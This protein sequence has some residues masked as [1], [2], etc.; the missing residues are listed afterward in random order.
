M[1]SLASYLPIPNSKIVA[2]AFLVFSSVVNTLLAGQ[3]DF[4]KEEARTI[5]GAWARTFYESPPQKQPE[6][7]KSLLDQ[8]TLLKNKNPDRAEPLIVE[9]IILCTYSGSNIGLNSINML[10]EAR[11]L[12]ERAI[13][14]S[15]SALDG[16]AYVTLGNLYRRLPGW[17]IL[18]GDNE[19]A[20]HYF[21]AGLKLFPNGL[22][23]N[24]FYGDYLLSQGAFE[25][26]VTF[27]ERATNAQ[28]RPWLKISDAKLK[29]ESANS[30]IAAK[31]RKPAHSD[32]F[33]LFTPSF[34]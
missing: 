33:G 16:A 18:Y 10:E 3:P 27:L 19:L 9:A 12:L 25:K 23:T 1:V 26:A 21:E 4:V 34:E 30:L 31:N 11:G 15:P 2:C 24:Y 13:N 17:P 20:K 29:T 32:F 22:D 7:Y 6:E 8:A 28:V 14:I 5:Q